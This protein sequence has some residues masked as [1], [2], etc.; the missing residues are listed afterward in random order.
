[1]SRLHAGGGGTRLGRHL[2][3]AWRKQRLRIDVSLRLGGDPD[4][5]VNVGLLNL[6]LLARSD[7]PHDG[8]LFDDGALRHGDRTEVD[9]R[10]R[11]AVCRLDGDGLAAARHRTGERDGS[12]GSRA[13]G[14][15]EGA[16]DVD[17]AVLPGRIGVVSEDERPHDR[18]VRGPG[19]STSAWNERERKRHD[20]EQHLPHSKTS[21]CHI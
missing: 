6:G 4:P 16:R 13:Y 15:A 5:E 8:A 12:S 18:P 2:V 20:D 17:P 14:M 11:V 21:R 1:V 3:D 7:R 10:Y 9:V 19:P